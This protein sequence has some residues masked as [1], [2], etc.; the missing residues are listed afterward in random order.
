MRED[1]GDDGVVPLE[2]LVPALHEVALADAG[3]GLAAQFGGIGAAAEDV[4]SGGLGAAGNDGDL[5][6]GLAQTRDLPYEP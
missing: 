6:A 4:A 2:E 5:A 1:L 3:E